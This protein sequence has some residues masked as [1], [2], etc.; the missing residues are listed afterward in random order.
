[1][2]EGFIRNV[3][4]YLALQKIQ[5]KEQLSYRA[6]F[7]IYLVFFLLLA[8]QNFV[9]ITIIYGVSSGILGW[10]YYQMLALTS[11]ATLLFCI[12]VYTVDPNWLVEELTK[13]SLDQHLA[14]PVN[15]QLAL[16]SRTGSKEVVSSVAGAIVILAY[17]LLHLSFTPL[18]FAGFVLLFLTG[19]FTL[20]S[21]WLLIIVGSYHLFKK[22][23]FLYTMQG[24]FQT[25]GQYP[26]GLFG[27][28]GGLVLT[29][30]FPV[31][32][33]TNYPVAVLT[34]QLSPASYLGMLALAIVIMVLAYKGT[35]ELMKRYVSGGG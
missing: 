6:S 1:M 27:I 16:L 34:G 22:G 26:I 31:A 17:T 14:R 11:T 15:T 24:I 18:E 19:L 28:F 13:G 12:I 7:V 32:L 29:L 9:A 35:G 23:G 8:L 33:A 25:S 20:L 2:S 5:W 21:V 4:V 30:V 10:S 3:R